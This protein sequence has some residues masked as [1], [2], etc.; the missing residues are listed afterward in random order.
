MKRSV[1]SLILA[2]CTGTT[3]LSGAVVFSSAGASSDS[4]VRASEQPTSRSGVVKYAHGDTF[5]T[6]APGQHLFLQKVVIAP[7]AQMSTHFHQG[8][9]IAYVSAGILNYDVV[10]GTVAITKPNGVSR[11]V[12][13]PRTIRLPA[14]STLVETPSLV[15]YGSN[16][17]T[18]PVV[19]Q[20]ASLLENGAPLST[21]VGLP[22]VAPTAIAAALSS[23]R[24]TLH[25]V[26]T[27]VRY[28]WNDLE[29]DGTF[30]SQPVHVE[31]LGNVAYTAGTGQ[32]FG[33]VTF[34][35]HDGSTLG[36]QMQGQATTVSETL[37]T[38]AASL[39]VLGGTGDYAGATSGSGIF[40]GSRN[41]PV[42]SPVDATFT[43]TLPP[44][45]PS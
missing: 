6:N 35:F 43:Y 4:R 41:G 30:D 8:T 45:P 24:T 40:T 26:G 31:M 16:A 5:P 23:S 22:A 2:T 21:P 11:S 36:F 32:F 3:A 10:S 7:G 38:V 14:G 13:G 12:V 28:G 37:V 17:G 15:H 29:G 25:S 44:S 1:L 9:Q 39:G 34:T 33:F 20:L 18:T 19:I 27:N 42:G